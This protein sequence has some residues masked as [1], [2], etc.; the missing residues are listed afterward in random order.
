[1]FNMLVFLHDEIEKARNLV[2]F[3]FED[4]IFLL[5]SE[6]SNLTCN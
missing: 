3:F 1:M 6:F 2:S 5:A 4:K